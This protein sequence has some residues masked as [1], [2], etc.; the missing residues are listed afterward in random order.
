MQNLDKYTE[1]SH[2]VYE[3][4]LKIILISAI[5]WKIHAKQTKT[6]KNDFQKKENIAKMACRSQITIRVR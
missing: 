1:N 2:R 4:S 5:S 6:H 3:K